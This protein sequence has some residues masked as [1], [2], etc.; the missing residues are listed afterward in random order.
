MNIKLYCI[1]HLLIYLTLRILSH[2]GQALHSFEKRSCS[3]P[4]ESS[5]LFLTPTNP[6][7]DPSKYFVPFLENTLLRLPEKPSRERNRGTQS[8]C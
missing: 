4:H 1:I 7:P 8:A 2:S 3:F 5:P 6:N